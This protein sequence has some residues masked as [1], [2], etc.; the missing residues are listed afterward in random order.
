MQLLSIASVVALGALLGCSDDGGGATARGPEGGI[1]EV[2]NQG[3]PLG[4]KGGSSGSGSLGGSGGS[5]GGKGG[6]GGTFTTGGKP[7]AGPTDIGKA[8]EDDADCQGGLRCRRDTTNFIS[9]LQCSMF[10]DTSEQCENLD[11]SSFCIGANACVHACNSAADCGPKT[12]CNS[13]GWCERKG[14]GSGVSFCTPTPAASPRSAA[15]T[16]ASATASPPAATRSSIASL[17]TSKT[18]AF[19]AAQPSHAAASPARAAA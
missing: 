1:L 9:H 10:C 19:G 16:T 14:P 4:E 8:C 7:N 18:A 3:I 5:S 15:K 11:A 13:S 12:R 2:D 17:A 6:T